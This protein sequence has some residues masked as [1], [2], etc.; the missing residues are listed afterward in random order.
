M[1]TSELLQI[2]GRINPAAWDFIIPHGP[3]VGP[4]GAAAAS[5][6][7]I[8]ALNPQ[9]LP[10]EPDPWLIEAAAMAR[11]LV[12]QAVF[13]SMR[14][15]SDPGWVREIIDDWCGTPWPRKW[16]WPWPG[17][18]PDPDPRQVQEARLVGAVILASYGSRLRE[19]DLGGVLTDLADRLGE[20]ALTG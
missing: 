17:P 2:I 14:G 4:R 11:E 7:D 13:D 8:A 1:A 9:P 15:Q 5:R 19:S 16:P 10:P 6:A 18:G 12:Q 20:A 3:L